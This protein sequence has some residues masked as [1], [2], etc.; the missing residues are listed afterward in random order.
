MRSTKLLIH[1]KSSLWFVPV[2][3]VLAGAA[4]SFGTIALDRYF[5]YEALPTRLVG[6]PDA[7]AL[8]KPNPGSGGPLLHPHLT[9]VEDRKGP[10]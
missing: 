3:C 2:L 7:A 1:L 10:L 9:L 5:D 6:G 4:L 8:A